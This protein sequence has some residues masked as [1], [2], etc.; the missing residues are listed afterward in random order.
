MEFKL[1]ASIEEMKNV[2]K[3][4]KP[5]LVRAGNKNICIV[6]FEDKLIAFENECPHMGESLHNGHVNHFGE[7]ICPLHSYRFN[8]QSGETTRN[9]AS[10]KSVKVIQ[11]K[12]V[13]LLV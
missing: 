7:I 8:M 3:D 1:F 11:E 6:L 5:R 10:L 4:K 13:F 9:C 2:L 12:E